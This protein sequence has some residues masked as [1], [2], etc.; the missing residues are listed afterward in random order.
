MFEL[1]IGS[2]PAIKVGFLVIECVIGY[3]WVGR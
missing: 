2:H 3:G 1:M